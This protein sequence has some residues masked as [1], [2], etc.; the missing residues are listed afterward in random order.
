MTGELRGGMGHQY[1][2]ASVVDQ[3]LEA[4]ATLHKEGKRVNSKI[5][6]EMTR[7]PASWAFAILLRHGEQPP[8]R[9]RKPKKLERNLDAP[10][11]ALREE[12]TETNA[13]APLSIEDRDRQYRAVI[14]Q[15]DLFESE[16]QHLTSRG[17]RPEENRWMG[18]RSWVQGKQI[19][20]V[21]PDLPGIKDGKLVTPSG[22]AIPLKDPGDRIVGFQIRRLNEE[23][24]K[25]VWVSSTFH[26][27]KG[28]HLPN[29][30]LPLQFC[31]RGFAQSDRIGLAEGVL[32]PWM[33]AM[34]LRQIVI[35]AAGGQWAYSPETFREYLA[36]A[37]KLLNGSK[38]VVLY[39]DAGAV[40][41]PH[42]MRNYR[43]AV[44]LC[45]EWGYSVEV[46]WWGQVDKQ[47][48]DIDELLEEGLKDKIDYISTESFFLL[49]EFKEVYSLPSEDLLTETDTDVDRAY[50]V[51][52]DTLRSRFHDAEK[53]EAHFPV[54][55]TPAETLAGEESHLLPKKGN[56]QTFT[57]K[58]AWRGVPYPEQ[59]YLGYY[60]EDKE[61]GEEV[62]DPRCNFD[63]SVERE[64][65]DE[66]GGGLVLNVKR[67][68]ENFHRRAIVSSLAWASPKDFLLALTKALGAGIVMNLKTHELAALIQDKYSSYRYRGGE[69]YQLATCLG[70]QPNGTWVFEESQLDDKGEPIT[71]EKSLT[72]WNPKLTNEEKIRSPKVLERSPEALPRLTKAMRRFFGSNFMPALFVMGYCAA[73]AHF[74]KIIKEQKRFP[75][76][77]VFGDPMGGKT[78][79]V[80]CG[81]SLFGDGW[82]F[83][84]I[85]SAITY[86]A[87]W[88]KA[89]KC[90]DMALCL[91]DPAQEPQVLD[92][93]VRAWYNAEQRSVRGNVQ[94]P[95]SSLII[96][97]NHACGEKLPAA[98]TRLI[99][100]WFPRPGDKDAT[101]W[102]E[103]QQAKRL[104]SGALSDIIKIGYPSEEIQALTAEIAAA[105]PEA[106]DRL[107]ASLALL[108]TYTLKIAALAGIDEAEVKKF[109]F[110]TLCAS[111]ES[112]GSNESALH[113]F[114]T[115]LQTAEQ[116][117]LVGDWNMK[118]IISP[119]GEM[120]WLALALGAFDE[121]NN[122]VKLPYGKKVIAKLITDAGGQTKNAVQRFSQTKEEVNAYRRARISPRIYEGREIKPVIPPT[123]PR[124]CWLVPMVEVLNAWG[125]VPTTTLGNDDENGND[126]EKNGN[127]TI[128]NGNA[129][130]ASVSDDLILDP[131]QEVLPAVT[132][133]YQKKVT[134]STPHTAS[135]SGDE[136]TTV[137]IFPEHD[138]TF[139]QR[140]NV[141]RENVNVKR[142]NVE[143]LPPVS[144]EWIQDILNCLDPIAWVTSFRLSLAYG[145]P[146][147]QVS[148]ALEYLRLTEVAERSLNADTETYSYRLKPRE[149]SAI[150]PTVP[151]EVV[152]PTVSR[153]EQTIEKDEPC[154]FAVGDRVID[155]DYPHCLGEVIEI[156]H[157]TT[158]GP[159]DTRKEWRVVVRWD[160][161][162]TTSE[163]PDWFFKTAPGPTA[164]QPKAMFN[165]IPAEP[166]DF[167][168]AISKALLPICNNN[169]YRVI[170]AL[171]VILKGGSR[172]NAY[173]ELIFK[174]LPIGSFYKHRSTVL[175][176]CKKSLHFIR[177]NDPKAVSASNRE[178]DA[179]PGKMLSLP[180][181]AMKLRVNSKILADWAKKDPQKFI[182][183]TKEK[184]PQ[185]LGYHRSPGGKFFK[186]V[187]K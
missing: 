117:S 13:I 122:M 34:R 157:S 83:D 150:A 136:K 72:I 119:A 59:G 152:E 129:D 137:T 8:K 38:K 187:V 68:D 108:G 134:P 156:K 168:E 37:S 181:L 131:Q 27:G 39:P 28:P 88:Q 106:S 54:L 141:K 75:I 35:G 12:E 102:E 145:W 123:V 146:E 130:T 142:E 10:S 43:A 6:S 15:L 63:F 32:K 81:L 172:A 62:F 120:Q 67:V 113:H 50:T 53:S 36:V 169:A 98:A 171:E 112:E 41:N 30:E 132:G 45:E 49:S 128:E 115:Q 151:T 21:S 31:Q 58:P 5:V 109:L 91:D 182:Q 14:S 155:E 94:R 164:E 61:T 9:A 166:I 177:Q 85:H 73:S 11:P 84:G 7:V 56:T 57:P 185:G 66:E 55:V 186:Q 97:S 19:D 159:K 44:D 16:N 121:V 4:S 154:Q 40:R 107:P 147:E 33:P 3:V 126:D 184:D 135:V 133:C 86:S 29:G 127:S 139:L 78:V 99:W 51:S 175:E 149:E 69:T 101:A 178:F 103:L 95:T 174:E 180:Q 65:S 143:S 47:Q 116:K 2:E 148:K 111:S 96:A 163:H 76:L 82:A 144:Q 64:L 48:L 179:L 114:L 167:Q 23:K 77:N 60:L 24:N 26:G 80:E 20:G 105:M 93:W 89:S 110:E 42:V 138:T 74:Q 70:R 153:E 125:S 79:A 176:E 165:V 118:P 18:C 22:L 161:D 52:H 183:L 100:M 17:F 124:K 46:A 92:E 104:A 71:E 90:G 140:E 158:G 160:N 170:E 162:S 173:L 1:I 87:L 25:Y